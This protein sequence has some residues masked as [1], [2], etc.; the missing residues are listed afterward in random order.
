MRE[1][2]RREVGSPAA[3]RR[4]GPGTA[5]WL[6]TGR[7]SWKTVVPVHS[8]R[9]TFVA[10]LPPQRSSTV[11]VLPRRSTD[12]VRPLVNVPSGQSPTPSVVAVAAQG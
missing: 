4:A 8:R 6:P 11:R 12:V 2:L 10:C 9:R 5:I 1:I 7:S 3:A